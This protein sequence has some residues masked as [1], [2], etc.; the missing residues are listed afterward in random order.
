M[1]HLIKY[2]DEYGTLYTCKTSLPTEV[3]IAHIQETND[4]HAIIVSIEEMKCETC[5][6]NVPSI[7]ACMKHGYFPSKCI[8]NDFKDYESKQ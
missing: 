3:K 2:K 1:K 7:E 6:H 8:D 4:N 5:A